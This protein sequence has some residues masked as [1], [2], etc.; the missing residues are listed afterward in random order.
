MKNNLRDILKEKNISRYKMAK[1]LGRKWNTINDW[2]KS[3]NMYVK[4]MQTCSN[5]LGVD[6]NDLF[7]I[8]EQKKTNANKHTD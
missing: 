6:I 7:K 3:D 8:N 5:Y 2:C 1:D 4:D